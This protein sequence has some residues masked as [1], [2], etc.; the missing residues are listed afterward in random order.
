MKTE[1]KKDIR[2]TFTVPNDWDIH[3]FIAEV[4]GAYEEI[5]GKGAS[6]MVTYAYREV[7]V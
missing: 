7:A 2:V 3:D 6:D 5:A 1:N 4:M